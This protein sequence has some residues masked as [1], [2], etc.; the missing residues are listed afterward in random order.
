MVSVEGAARG[1]RGSWWWGPLTL[2]TGRVAGGEHKLRARSRFF[3][4][5]FKLGRDLP[6]SRVPGERGAVAPRS[7]AQPLRATA[8]VPP[9][10]FVLL[11]KG[12]VQ[13]F[14]SGMRGN[15]EVEDDNENGGQ[16]RRQEL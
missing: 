5:A 4:W 14:E 1:G 15:E 10:L 6:L 11:V 13:I 8:A 2:E 7:A 9:A 12:R 3:V 16:G